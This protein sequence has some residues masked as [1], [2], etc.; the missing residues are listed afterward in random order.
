[1]Y[2]LDKAV[3]DAAV[4][5]NTAAKTCRPIY[6]P[7]S[8]KMA[9]DTGVPTSSPK[10]ARQKDVPILPPATAKLGDK[11]VTMMTFGRLRIAPE[12]NPKIKAN[13]TRLPVVVQAIQIKAMTLDRAKKGTSMFIGPVLS[14]KKFGRIRP[15]IPPAF[16]MGRMKAGSRLFPMLCAWAKD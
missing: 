16:R 7:V 1:M 8:L 6:D 4:I 12:Q 14:A 10:E 13:T 5:K 15:T 11:I 2:T 3:N 9:P